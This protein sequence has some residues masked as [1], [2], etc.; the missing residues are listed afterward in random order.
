MTIMS[1]IQL[2]QQAFKIQT[3]QWFISWENLTGRLQAAHQ[4]GLQH[5]YTYIF[6]DSGTKFHCELDISLLLWQ[7]T[8]TRT[9]HTVGQ[10][11]GV[12]VGILAGRSLPVSPQVYQHFFFPQSTQQHQTEPCVWGKIEMERV[13]QPT[14]QGRWREDR[15][16]E[17]KESQRGRGRR[18][19]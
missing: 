3:N 11:D 10:E 6:T 8:V 7:H 14:P 13:R 1:F 18:E 5:R 17:R 16:N 4:Q 15:V 2:C 12:M 19:D 9:A